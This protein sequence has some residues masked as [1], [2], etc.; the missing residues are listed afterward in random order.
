MITHFTASALR[1]EA[2]STRDAQY[3]NAF[4]LKILLNQMLIQGRPSG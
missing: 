2:A 1:P 3:D 4:E